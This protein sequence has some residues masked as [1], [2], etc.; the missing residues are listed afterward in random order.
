MKSSV[1]SDL[2]INRHLGLSDTDEQKM[3]SELGFNKIDQFIE[4]VIPDEIHLKLQFPNILWVIFQ[5]TYLLT[6]YLQV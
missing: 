4:Q 3:L 6:E 5:K 1:N 2:F